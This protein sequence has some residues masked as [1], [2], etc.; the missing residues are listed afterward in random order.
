MSDPTTAFIRAQIRLAAVPFVSGIRLYQAAEPVG[1]WELAGGDYSSDRPPPFWAFAWAGGQALARYVIDHPDT[2]RG[3]R[4]LDLACG[5]GI[6]AVAAATAG[7]AA[8]HAVDV[9]PDAV[10]AVAR[11]AAA[12]GVTVR[13]TLGDILAGDA[14][15]AEVVLVGD[16]FYSGAM[17]DRVLRF[18]R[19]AARDG[20]RVL[21]GDPDRKF[22]PRRLFR[23]LR[24]YDVPTR[25]ALEDV[26]VKRTTI[27]ELPAP[28]GLSGRPD[29]ATDPDQSSSAQ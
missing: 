27:W 21:V 3:R 12:N 13:T 10:R 11:N 7:A 4:V 28:A 15:D 9:D 5:S 23:P 17:A 22:L 20:A 26:P 1:L 29:S 16:A 8:V 6:V 24:V 14:G 19:R 25:P 2:V 18:L